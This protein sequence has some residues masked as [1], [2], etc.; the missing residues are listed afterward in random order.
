MT[1]TRKNKKQRNTTY[2]AL[3]K[4]MESAIVVKPT[5]KWPTV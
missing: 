1:T 3:R 2:N 5:M 4:N